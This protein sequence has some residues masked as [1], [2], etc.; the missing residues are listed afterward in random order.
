MSDEHVR[1]RNQRW[2]QL[3]EVVERSAAV[4]F[5][6]SQIAAY[7]LR[8]W[9][10]GDGVTLFRGLRLREIT[11][12]AKAYADS[13]VESGIDVEWLADFTAWSA[14]ADK[15]IQKRDALVHRSVGLVVQGKDVEG[16][17]WA[18]A[19]NK[20]NQEPIGSQ[21]T[22]LATTLAEIQD[23]AFPVLAA[24]SRWAGHIENR[25]TDGLPDS[26]NDP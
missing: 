23:V 15:A 25:E 8:P 19:R 12:R 22:D 21:L 14:K 2:L 10:P 4:E 20:Q 7:L 1:Q 13:L 16:W 26:Q 5:L 6:A 3:G 11:G 9:L 18:P 24:A 17:A